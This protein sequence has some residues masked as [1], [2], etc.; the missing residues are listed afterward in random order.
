MNEMPVEYQQAF[1]RLKRAYIQRLEN[2]VRIIDNILDLEQYSLPSREDLQRAQ[3]LVH[4]LCGS[5]TTFGFPEITEVGREADH[6]LD[7]FIKGMLPGERINSVMDREFDSMMIRVRDVCR[8]TCL[9]GRIDF[10]DLANINIEEMPGSAGHPHILIVEDDI[11]VASAMANDLMSQGMTAQI[12][13]NAEDALHYLAR[14]RPNLA[15]VDLELKG[16]DGIEL[17][18]QIKQNSE[19]IDIPVLIMSART[20]EQEELRCMRGGAM[21]FIRKPLDL[22]SITTMIQDVL[23]VEAEKTVS[24]SPRV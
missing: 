19:Y 6:F 24:V 11:H 17:L 9:Q 12:T 22:A 1:N 16:M 8:S 5:G 7:S 15:L 3:A 10:P 4:G 13:T 2:T 14:V 21:G 20:R 23:R 18:H